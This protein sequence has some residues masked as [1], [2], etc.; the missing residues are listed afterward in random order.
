M[1]ESLRE[2]DLSDAKS[3]NATSA[4]SGRRL[5]LLIVAVGAAACAI[6]LMR[7]RLTEERI[8]ETIIST[9]ASEARESFYV[10]GT[11]TFSTTVEER[12]EKSLLPS[13]I[14]LNL[15]TTT[16]TVRVPGR[17]AYGFDVTALRAEHIR[18][19]DVGVVEVGVPE[20]EVFSVEPELEN[21]DIQTEVGWARLHRSSGQETEQR[22]LQAIRPTMQAT[23]ERH[24]ANSTKPELN[25]AEALARLLTPA[26]EAGGVPA[27]RFR[28]QLPSG[29][30]LELNVS[31]SSS[32]DD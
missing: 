6:W 19:N 12:S 17:V 10:T 2:Q 9:L 3:L 27:P 5:I 16:A 25:T 14:N 30:T 26:L 28:F 29:G 32:T 20:L 13:I 15:G 31:E 21:V 22:A 8:Q 7:P 4:G 11:L 23:A 18:Y 1:T 24:L